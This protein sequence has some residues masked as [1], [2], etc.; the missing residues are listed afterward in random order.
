[1]GG[2]REQGVRERVLYKGLARAKRPRRKPSKCLDVCNET[3][4]T[5]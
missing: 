4:G 5:V 1:M 3:P 2:E